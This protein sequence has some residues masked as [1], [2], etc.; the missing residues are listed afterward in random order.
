MNLLSSPRAQILSLLLGLGLALWVGVYAVLTLSVYPA[1]ERYEYQLAASEVA[2]VEQAIDGQLDLLQLIN[3]EYSAWDDMQR[4]AR[5]PES[6]P[7]FIAREMYQDYWWPVGIEL[8][9]ILDL[10]GG[11]RW[12]MLTEVGGP[13]PVTLDDL[14]LGL[15]TSNPLLTSHAG[16]H[17]HTRGLIDTPAGLLMIVSSPITSSDGSGPVTGSFIVG[18]TLSA[19]HLE[20]LGKSA[21]ARVTMYFLADPGVTAQVRDIPNKLDASGQN[22]FLRKSGD[23]QY[24]LSQLRDLYGDAAAVVQTSTDRASRANGKDAI[25]FA[26]GYLALAIAG[27]LFIA[28][29]LLSAWRER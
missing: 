23:S 26:I 16:V 28:W 21:D 22:F 13:G 8:L 5:D 29:W 2:R 27:F 12:G 9:L 17:S 3:R 25:N 10:D 20:A 15:F 4:Y 24:M 19:V 1:F 14:V 18:R 6:M 11:L 7:G